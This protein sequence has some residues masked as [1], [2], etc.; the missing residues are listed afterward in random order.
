MSSKVIRI[1]NEEDMRVL[2]VRLA[3][4]LK[5]GDVVTLAGGLGAGKTVF[6]RALINA[7]SPSEERASV[8]GVVEDGRITVSETATG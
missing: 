1:E 8:L 6:A 5:V 4:I 7:L 3:Q 2:A